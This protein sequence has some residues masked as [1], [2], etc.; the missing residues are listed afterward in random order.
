MGA[1]GSGKGAARIRLCLGRARLRDRRSRRA[2]LRKRSGLLPTAT[3]VL[4][5][6][7][8]GPAPLKDFG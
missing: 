7:V 2:G 6:V 5:N 3:R 1:V 8:A 4:G